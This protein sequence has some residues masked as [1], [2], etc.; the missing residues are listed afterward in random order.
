MTG[1]NL[2]LFG[3][4]VLVVLILGPMVTFGFIMPSWLT[5][6]EM[7]EPFKVVVKAFEHIERSAIL[8]FLFGLFLIWNNDAIEIGD[9]WVGP[10]MGLFIVAMAIGMGVIGPTSKKAIALMDS[11]QSAAGLVNRLRL[12]NLA[13]FVLFLAITWLMVAKPG[14]G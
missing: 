9:K 12:S 6:P 2:L 13:T 8:I 1:R 11:G 5:R 14:Q 7:K 10:S 4:I 3:H